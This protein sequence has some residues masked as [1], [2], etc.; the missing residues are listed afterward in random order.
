[1]VTLSI[2][3]IVSNLIDDLRLFWSLD[4]GEILYWVLWGSDENC[5]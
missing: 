1:M 2:G 5:L 3:T 4:L